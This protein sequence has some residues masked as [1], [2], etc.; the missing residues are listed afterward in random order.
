[1][2]F[3]GF[4][5]LFKNLKNLFRSYFPVLEL[6][7]VMMTSECRKTSSMVVYHKMLNIE[8]TLQHL[9]AVCCG[10]VF[11]V[12]RFRGITEILYGMFFSLALHV[13][14]LERFSSHESNVQVSAAYSKTDITRAWHRRILVPSW[15]I[16][17]RHIPLMEDMT[18]AA[19]LYNPA[20]HV[21]TTVVIGPN[22]R[23]GKW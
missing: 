5:G 17:S 19:R 23:A 12:P 13:E 16:L 11:I 4:K 2:Y 1:M 21:W 8:K 7:D 18:D 10:G 20:L 22:G 9:S 14:C 15:R 3:W 6:A